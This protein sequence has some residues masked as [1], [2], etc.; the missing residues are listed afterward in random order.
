MM[1]SFLFSVFD[2]LASTSGMLVAAL[3]LDRLVG[4][5]KK[6]H[7]LVAFGRWVDICQR[8]LQLSLTD[9][10]TRQR[11]A[12]AVAWCCTVF[13]LLIMLLVLMSIL[14]DWLTTLLSIIVLYFTIGWQSLREHALAIAKPLIRG[15]LL[16][17][18][19]GVSR[20]VSRDTNQ[21]NET[22]V[23]KASIE[24]VLENG[25]DAVFA[26]IFWFLVLGV[27]GALLYRLANTLDA[28]WGY[29]TDTLLHFGWF[30]ARFDDMMNYIPARLVVLTYGLCGQFS[31]A[32]RCYQTQASSWKSPNAGP[33]MAAGAGALGI[34]LGGAAPYFGKLES[35]PELGEGR[36][37]I[38]TDLNKAIRLVDKGVYLWVLVV[39]LMM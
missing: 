26:P 30:A 34:K 20:I 11:Q 36:D 29:K 15:D 5:P 38:A 21:L 23:T 17:A 39:C 4:E 32:W 9:T 3:L 37:P 10:A 7:P 16:Q 35:R 14:P 13:P 12:G 6:W 27:P 25:S 22:Q 31:S 8:G 2:L 18:R 1:T 33:V 19:H 28:M 24:S